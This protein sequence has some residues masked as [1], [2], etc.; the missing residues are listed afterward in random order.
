MLSHVCLLRGVPLAPWPD[1]VVTQ[2]LG[3]VAELAPRPAARGGPEHPL[4]GCS[5]IAL[6]P[7]PAG[8]WGDVVLRELGERGA[9][10]LG[11]LLDV[12]LM[13][14]G[15]FINKYSHAAVPTTLFLINF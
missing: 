11:L 12:A 15:L 4:G 13:D 9:L 2:L 10:V 5:A 6:P 3:P 8:F 1:G 7:E 14:L